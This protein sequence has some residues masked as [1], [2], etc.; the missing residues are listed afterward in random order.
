MS[1]AAPEG[2]REPIRILLAN[3]PTIMSEWLLQMAT[4]RTDLQIVDRIDG[5]AD[6]LV[7]AQQGIDVVILGAR[8][9]PPAAGVCSH[10]LTADPDVRILLLSPSGDRAALYWLALRR[11][12]VAIPSAETLLAT[13]R[14]IDLLTPVYEE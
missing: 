4:D 13:L 6:L 7:A 14:Q 9:F 1:Q 2:H 8:D 3:L 10:L 11:R 5:Y 12:E